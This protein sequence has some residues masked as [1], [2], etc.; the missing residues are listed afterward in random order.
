M[1]KSKNKKTLHIAINVLFIAIIVV[2]YVLLVYGSVF[3]TNS[4]YYQVLN[5][6]F[7]IK[8]VHLLEENLK[9]VKYII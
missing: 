8:L 9:L 4:H 1:E 6:L 3:W 5:A 2:V 7:L